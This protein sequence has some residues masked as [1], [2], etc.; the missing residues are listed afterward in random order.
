M[1][2]RLGI[3]SPAVSPANGVRKKRRFQPTAETSDNVAAP[4]VFEGIL[5]RS[6]TNEVVRA[7][8]AWWG[9]NDIR[10]V[11]IV[12]IIKR[13]DRV[14]HF[15]PRGRVYAVAVESNAGVF[16]KRAVSSLS[17]FHLQTECHHLRQSRDRPN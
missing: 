13:D 5:I 17:S 6:K 1:S 9:T 4:A 15:N 10:F 2:R 7:E 12:V 16:R 3:V 14:V 11:H 8:E